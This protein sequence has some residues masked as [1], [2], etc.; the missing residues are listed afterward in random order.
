MARYRFSIDVLDKE[1]V[2]SSSDIFSMMEGALSA[3]KIDIPPDKKRS[4]KVV[5]AGA[6]A[7]DF[8]SHFGDVGCVTCTRAASDGL[9]MDVDDEFTALTI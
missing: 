2:L 7:G 4:V 6:T 8:H 5:K 3:A 9:S 1:G